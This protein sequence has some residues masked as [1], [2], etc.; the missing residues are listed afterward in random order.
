MNTQALRALA[1]LSV[2][3]LAIAGPAAAQP[4]PV[5]GPTLSDVERRIVAEAQEAQGRCDGEDDSPEARARLDELVAQLEE[6]GRSE[7]EMLPGLVG[8]WRQVWSDG[9]GGGP[10]CIAADDVYQVVFPNG[11]Y[12]N[13][14]RHLRPDGA[15]ATG[16]LKGTYQ[17][18]GE[19]LDIA[20]TRYE[21]REGWIGAG[22]D[23]GRAAMRI[24]AETGGEPQ[25]ADQA[26]PPVGQ[27]GTLDNVY[28]SDGL[29]IA[30]GGGEDYDGDFLYVLIRA[31]Q[32]G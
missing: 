29:R 12:Y 20:F 7:A 10:D 13:I 16:F 17:T 18:G 23:L 4:Q 11:Y 30:R 15:E 21:L 25:P 32:A 28:L 1:V 9:P 6:D 26:P 5:A 27:T 3:A 2:A 14:G 31:D 22:A 8:G 24:E 19:A